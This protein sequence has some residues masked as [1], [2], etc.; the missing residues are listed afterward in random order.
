MYQFEF[1]GGV[2]NLRSLVS[3]TGQRRDVPP[4]SEGCRLFVETDMEAA[5]FVAV[6]AAIFVALFVAIFLPLV[7]SG[8]GWRAAQDRAR[9][10]RLA[11]AR[12][13]ARLLR[14]DI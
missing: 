14:L 7:L 11:D 10:R 5:R 4:E 9:A 6:F 12:M 13:N 2:L 8:E 1:L 3:W